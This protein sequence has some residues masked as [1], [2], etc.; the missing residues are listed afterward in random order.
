MVSVANSDSDDSAIQH[1]GTG[2]KNTKERLEILYGEKSQ[3]KVSRKNGMTIAELWI[4]GASFA[5][6]ADFSAA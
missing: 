3:F 4:S 6:G 1:S 2:L 5:E